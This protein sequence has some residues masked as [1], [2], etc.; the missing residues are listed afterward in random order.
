MARTE[1]DGSPKGQSIELIDPSN[2]THKLHAQIKALHPEDGDMI[3]LRYPDSRHIT[4]KHVNG[5][6][7]IL[8]ESIVRLGVRAVVV[9]CPN[10]WD[11]ELMTHKHAVQILGM[12]D[13]AKE[14]QKD[15]D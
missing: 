9:A 1:R 11:V 5:C 4:S 6:A 2:L 15:L 10:D 14:G 13:E 7:E 8:R 3:V 12:I